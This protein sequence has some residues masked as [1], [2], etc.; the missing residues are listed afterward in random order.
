MT[1]VRQCS[2]K[3]ATPYF[4]MWRRPESFSS[5]SECSSAGRPWQSQPNRRSTCLPRIVW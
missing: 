1:E 4:R 5:V 3:R 2:L